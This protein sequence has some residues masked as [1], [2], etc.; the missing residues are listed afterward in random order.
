VRR[1][2]SQAMPAGERFVVTDDGTPGTRIVEDRATGITFQGCTSLPDLTCGAGE[3]T[4]ADAPGHCRD[5]VWAGS[6][7]WRVPTYKELQAIL[8]KEAGA[9]DSGLPAGLSVRGP[10]VFAAP[11]ALLAL[12]DMSRVGI[13]IPDKVYPVI[14]ARGPF[15]P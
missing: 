15:A 8:D 11:G 13:G 2:F 12:D 7:D 1:G 4:S 5:L 6:S 14:C 3:Y 9:F 10:Y